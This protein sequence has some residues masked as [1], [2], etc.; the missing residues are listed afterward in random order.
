MSCMEMDD[1]RC[2]S[3][4]GRYITVKVTQGA[5]PIN[6]NPTIGLVTCLKGTIFYG[7]QIAEK[8]RSRVEN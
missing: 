4:E 8:R 6:N 2:R 1:F 7:L 3:I 5:H